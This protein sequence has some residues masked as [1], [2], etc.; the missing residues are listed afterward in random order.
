LEA[1]AFRILEDG[2]EEASNEDDEREEEEMDDKS[3]EDEEEEEEEDDDNDDVLVI[4]MVS[5]EMDW[6]EDELAED[7]WLDESEDARLDEI[8]GIEEEE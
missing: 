5:D 2:L 6:E 3:A 8:G 4:V 1:N 7:C